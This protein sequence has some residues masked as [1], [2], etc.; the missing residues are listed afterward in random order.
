MFPQGTKT[1]GNWGHKGRPGKVGG[2]A[3]G[4]GHE[5]LVENRD[6]FK[7]NDGKEYSTRWLQTG[8]KIKCLGPS[9]AKEYLKDKKV[10]PEASKE[11]GSILGELKDFGKKHPD[12]RDGT[13]DAKTYKDAKLKRGF[14]VTFHQN[15][16]GDD[17]FGGYDDETYAQMISDAK[18]RLQSKSVYFGNYGN[19]EVSFVTEDIDDAMD[20]AVENNQES[21]WDNKAGALYT[22]P[23][24]K[25][26]Y[27][28][29]LRDEKDL[30]DYIALKEKGMDPNFTEW[31]KIK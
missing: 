19:P 31:G 26:E 17:P 5:W 20:Y 10:S 21:I 22:N 9:G 14:S 8:K 13:F 15:K 30:D 24:Y 28:S 6:T 25:P 18:E 4:G 7:T 29:I 11:Y 12:L 3:P 2:S 1:S 16:A 23:F 27:N